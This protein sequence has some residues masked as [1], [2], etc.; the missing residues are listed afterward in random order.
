M[1]A[2]WC[3]VRQVWRKKHAC[4]WAGNPNQAGGERERRGLGRGQRGRLPWSGGGKLLHW[5]HH[6]RCVGESCHHNQ[7]RTVVSEDVTSDGVR[8]SKGSERARNTRQGKCSLS[9]ELYTTPTPSPYR[10]SSTSACPVQLA[11]IGRRIYTI[12]GSETTS[13]DHARYH[14]AAPGGFPLSPVRPVAS[15]PPLL[16]PFVAVQKIQLALFR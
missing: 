16:Y 5:D 12:A 11:W 10:C 2:G 6:G 7:E 9:F 1:R 8:R 4:I 3:G 15:L 13:G 14:S